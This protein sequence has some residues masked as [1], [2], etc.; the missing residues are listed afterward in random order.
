MENN[1]LAPEPW[2]Q[3]PNLFNSWV[4][5]ILS[6][7]SICFPSDGNCTTYEDPYKAAVEQLDKKG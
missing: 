6:V 1:I 2:I 3:S 4:S 5:Y 7:C